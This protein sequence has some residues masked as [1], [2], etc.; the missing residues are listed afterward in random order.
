MNKFD[1]L[2]HLFPYDSDKYTIDD[3]QYT[4]DGYIQMNDDGEYDEN[5]EIQNSNIE[6]IKSIL[7]DNNLTIEDYNKLAMIKDLTYELGRNDT[8]NCGCDCGCG[9]DSLDWDEEFRLDEDYREQIQELEECLK[10][11]F[12]QRLYAIWK[13]IY[14]GVMP[15]CIYEPICHYKDGKEGYD[16]HNYFDHFKINMIMIKCLIMKTEHDSTHNFH[17][18]KIKKYFFWQYK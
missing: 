1:T 17:K 13:C 2:W 3:L 8:V 16:L 7:I 14:F 18:M 6:R 5:I 9:G 12:K 10:N 11:D 15:S 4:L